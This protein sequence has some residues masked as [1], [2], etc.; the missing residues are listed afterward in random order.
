VFP[1]FDSVPS[2]TTPVVT[3]GIIGSCFL[4][5]FYELH[6]GAEQLQRFFYLFGFVPAR[7]T[8]SR[9]ADSVGFPARD[10]WPFITSMFLHAGWLHIIGN[11]W[12]LWI[13]G[14]NVEDRLGPRRFAAFYLICGIAASVVHWLTNQDSTVPALGASGAIAGVM[15]A[16]LVLFPK[17][18]I[19]LMIPVLFIPFFFEVPAVFF[20]VFW[21]LLQLVSGALALSS[22][23]HASGVAFWAHVGGFG[24]GIALLP[25]FLIGRPKRARNRDDYRMEAAWHRPRRRDH[26]S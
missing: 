23:Q 15:G 4:V 8:D 20:L 9:W 19:V 13:F 18:R 14:D 25:L 6:L 21:Y 26:R 24:A 7:F 10:Y 12:V 3:F 2:R 5:F 22:T 1:L 17:A 11:M 16:Y